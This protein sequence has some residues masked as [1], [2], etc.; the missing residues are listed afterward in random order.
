MIYRKRGLDKKAIAMTFDWIFAI[1]V[2]GFILFF[3]VFSA[4]KFIR[5]SEQVLYTET[6]ASLISLFDPLETGLASGKSSEIIFKKK[7][8]IFWGCNENSNKPFGKQT[9]RFTEQTFGDEYGEAGQEI[10]IKDKYVFSEN[11]VEGKEMYYFT[12]PFFAGFKVNDLLIIYSNQN[13]YCVYNANEDFQ[14]DIEGLNLKN[15]NFPNKTDKCDGVEICFGGVEGR[16]C[17]IKVFE[18][19][20]YVLKNGRKL[21]YVNDLIYGAVFSSSEIY[22]CNVK[23]IKSRFNELAQIYLDKIEVIERKNCEPKLGP[24]LAILIEENIRNSN[25]LLLFNEKIGEINEI[26]QRAKDGCKVYYNINWER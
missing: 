12:K 5:T 8:K 22:E 4:G 3:A 16:K 15:I 24:K 18:D 17:D 2:G 20:N 1:I 13:N 6:A 26:N 25:D 19:Q 23:R 11:V 21:Y 7:S 9:I 10:T 14:D